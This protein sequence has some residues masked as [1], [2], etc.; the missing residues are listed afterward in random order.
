MK[1]HV[2]NSGTTPTKERVSLVP[3]AD[4]GITL[5][6]TAPATMLKVKPYSSRDHKIRYEDFY[7]KYWPHLPQSA[8][9][10]LGSS[11]LTGPRIWWR[12]FYL[13]LCRSSPRLERVPGG[14]P[15][16]GA[17][18]RGPQWL[19]GVDEYTKTLVPGLKQRFIGIAHGYTISS[20]PT[21]N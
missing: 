7:A 20:R 12:I 5:K 1:D 17:I 11:P 19:L 3:A 15:R 14:D 16:L 9:K 8:A 13:D 2:H 21:P 6:D 10:G 4:A 18:F